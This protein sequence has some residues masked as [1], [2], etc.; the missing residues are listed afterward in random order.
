LEFS[1]NLSLG[2]EG[3]KVRRHR[4]SRKRRRHSCCGRARKERRSRRSVGVQACSKRS[5]GSFAARNGISQAAYFNWKKYGGL[6]PDEMRRLKAPG[7][8]NGRLEMIVADPTPDRETV[9]G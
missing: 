8:E 7:D 1:A 6:L 9:S 5:S 3:A 4:G 2:W